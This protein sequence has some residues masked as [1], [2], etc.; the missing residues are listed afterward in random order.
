MNKFFD[1]QKYLYGQKQ[2]ICLHVAIDKDTCNSLQYDYRQDYAGFR[3]LRL[4]RQYMYVT[5]DISS[6][7]SFL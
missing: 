3:A 6:F 5:I 2:F 7:W 1:A 4:S